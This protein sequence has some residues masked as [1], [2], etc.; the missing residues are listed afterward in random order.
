MRLLVIGAAGDLGARAQPGKIGLN[1]GAQFREFLRLK[2][3][4]YAYGAVAL[5]PLDDFS[6]NHGAHRSGRIVSGQS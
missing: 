4:P 3:L 6:G 2:Q 1:A 5:K